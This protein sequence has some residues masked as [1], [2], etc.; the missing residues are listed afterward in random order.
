M[1]HR[2]VIHGVVT[3]IVTHANGAPRGL[4][5]ARPALIDAMDGPDRPGGSLRPPPACATPRQTPAT[6]RSRGP[7]SRAPRAGPDRLCA[8]GELC[9]KADP[10]ARCGEARPRRK[11]SIFHYIGHSRL[12]GAARP[13]KR[14]PPRARSRALGLHRRSTAACS[15]RA[16]RRVP[17]ARSLQ[18][19]RRS[20]SRVRGVGVGQPVERPSSFP[21]RAAVATAGGCSRH[22]GTAAATRRRRGGG[23]VADCES[24]RLRGESRDRCGVGRGGPKLAF[25]RAE[26]RGEAKRAEPRRGEPTRGG[27]RVGRDQGTRRGETGVAGRVGAWRRTM[28]QVAAVLTVIQQAGRRSLR[29]GCCF[30]RAVSKWL[31]ENNPGAR[32]KVQTDRIF[33]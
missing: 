21:W 31:K 14:R 23:A 15:A 13:T 11:T 29:A 1:I 24:R 22:A 5:G 27:P 2:P 16:A 33:F 9:S 28:Y 25:A 18:I 17:R 20:S 7:P 26:V 6:E 4:R 12:A 19:A 30:P 8:A 32:R 3:Q 10:T